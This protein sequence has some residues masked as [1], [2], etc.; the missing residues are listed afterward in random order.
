MLWTTPQ[1]FALCIVLFLIIYNMLICFCVL[2]AEVKQA[3]E[4]FCQSL[5]SAVSG[6]V[7][8]LF[9]VCL[10]CYYLL[11]VYRSC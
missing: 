8:S 1:R 6:T 3:I 4:E 5:P 11:I 2:Q 7:S 9:I 10:C